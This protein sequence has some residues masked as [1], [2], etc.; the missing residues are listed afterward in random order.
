M[1]TLTTWLSALFILNRIVDFIFI[2][3]LIMQFFI[4]YHAESTE[5]TPAHWVTDRGL[6]ARHYLRTWFTLDAMSIAVSSFDIVALSK[7]GGSGGVSHLKILRVLRALRLVKLVRLVKSARL[8]KRWEMRIAVNYS[9][10]EV[11]KVLVFVFFLAHLFACIWGLQASFVQGGYTDSWLG[12]GGYC[13]PLASLNASDLSAMPATYIGNNYPDDYPVVWKDDD[14]ACKQSG[15]IYFAALYWAV[16]TITSIGYGDISATAASTVEQVVA[17]VLM[18]AGSF[19]WAKVVAVFVVVSD[20]DV[21]DR[22]FK[23]MLDQLNRFMADKQIP[24]EMRQRLR[25]YFHH[26]K[27]LRMTE[28]NQLLME[29]MSAQLQ[30]E[31]AWSVHHKWLNNIFFIQGASVQFMVELALKLRPLV[32]APSELCPPGLLYI[33]SRGL[34]LFEGRLLAQGRVWGEDVILFSE[35]LRSKHCA[36]ALTF[37]DVLTI[38]RDEILEIASAFPITAKSIRQSAIRLATRRQFI[39]EAEFRRLALGLEAASPSPRWDSALC[40]LT[41]TARKI[42]SASSDRKTSMA[43]IG[44]RTSEGNG[45]FAGGRRASES[46]GGCLPVRNL[47]CARDHMKQ[48]DHSMSPRRSSCQVM[49]TD[50]VTA[51]NDGSPERVAAF[52]A[53]TALAGSTPQATLG[54]SIATHPSET[55]IS[56]AAGMHSPAADGSPTLLVQNHISSDTHRASTAAGADPAD[57]AAAADNVGQLGGDGRLRNGPSRELREMREQLR[58]LGSMQ[59]KQMVLMSRMAEELAGVRSQLGSMAESPHLSAEHAAAEHAA[60][61]RPHNSSGHP[62]GLSRAASKGSSVKVGRSA[63]RSAFRS[64]SRSM[65]QESTSSGSHREETAPQSSMQQCSERL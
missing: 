63:M 27:H 35:H 38:D 5:R 3:D 18:L 29:N 7:E 8:L 2:V 39:L 52:R 14:V 58:N 47:A 6:I 49:S 53:A 40:S 60:L 24:T 62:H 20:R 22:E 25:E 50:R 59:Q 9:L 54:A 4:V 13:V 46:T 1:R 19:M 10:I 43:S 11:A 16:M 17:T 41:C 34:A 51:W 12:A 45:A 33:V 15:V 23:A 37:L 56:P 42:S 61:A 55:P 64:G 48:K 21:E 44:R 31:V 57:D 28:R 26:S 32:F 30:A 65:A 36:R